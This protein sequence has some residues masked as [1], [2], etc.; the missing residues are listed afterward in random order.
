MLAL[1]TD[2]GSPV[3]LKP[4]NL[5]PFDTLRLVRRAPGDVHPAPQKPMTWTPTADRADVIR[6]V[7]KY[8]E[9]DF[10][11]RSTAGKLVIHE[12]RLARKRGADI[13]IDRTSGP[14][15]LDAIQTAEIRR[16]VYAPP[17]RRTDVRGRDGEPMRIVAPLRD[18]TQ[19]V[20]GRPTRSGDVGSTDVRNWRAQV[21]SMLSEIGRDEQAALIIGAKIRIELQ[22]LRNQ[23]EQARSE[24]GRLKAGGRKAR[25][26]RRQADA[27]VADLWSREASESDRLKRLVRSSPYRH[28]VDHLL[29]VCTKSRE[30]EAYCFG[31][32][33]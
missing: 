20:T 23:L 22:T 15:I 4:R 8:V 27:R 28:G 19:V 32:V 11:I 25:D 26:L 1:T 12:G 13:D 16:A 24:A 3:V 18:L 17:P 33:A 21:A 14:E 9:K 31:D 2:C 10:S 6:M 30:R 7:Q 5:H 29:I